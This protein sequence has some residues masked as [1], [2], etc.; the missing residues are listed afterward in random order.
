VKVPD[1]KILQAFEMRRDCASEAP[2]NGGWC[3]NEGRGRHGAK[4]VHIDALLHPRIDKRNM[5]IFP[6]LF[7]PF[8][9]FY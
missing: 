3:E 2:E 5:K 9:A 8:L 7:R 4:H 6:F 1:V